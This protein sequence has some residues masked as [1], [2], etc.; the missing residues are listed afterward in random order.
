MLKHLVVLAVA[1]LVALG[2]AQ[3]VMTFSSA[4][5]SR[6]AGSAGAPADVAPAQTADAETPPTSAAPQDAEIVKAADGHYW[7]EAQVNGRWIHC[8]IDTG[9]TTVALTRADAQRLGLDT[10]DLT[11]D[12]PVNTANG[13][14]HAARVSLDYV[15]VAG[16]RVSAVPAMVVKD[17]L[18][19]SLLGMSYL[20]KLSRFEATPTSLILR[21]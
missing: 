19:V 9:A 16:A 21:P 3:E 14:T 5:A 10:A 11:F 7:A 2:M 17:G 18:S 20:G 1:V 8:L 4:H 6:A 13:Q 15:S 12:Q